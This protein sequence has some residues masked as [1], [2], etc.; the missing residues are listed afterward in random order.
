MRFERIL[1]AKLI[2]KTFLLLKLVLLG[3]C[4]HGKKNVFIQIF[5]VEAIIFSVNVSYDEKIKSNLLV[6]LIKYIF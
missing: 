4:E 3:F 5:M 2:Q 6:Q 1:Y